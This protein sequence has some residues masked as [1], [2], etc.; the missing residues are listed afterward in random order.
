MTEEWRGG[1]IEP[2][3]DGG[4]PERL[5]LRLARF[6][7]GCEVCGAMDWRA[8]GTDESGAIYECFNCGNVFDQP[9]IEEE[10]PN[11]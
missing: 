7:Q 6:A 10:G 4:V 9:V 1:K 3:A 8:K 2:P 5:R 11:V